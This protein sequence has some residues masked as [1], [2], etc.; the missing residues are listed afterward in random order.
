MWGRQKL[1][2]CV[3][4]THFFSFINVYLNTFMFVTIVEAQIYLKILLWIWKNNYLC[5]WIL[6]HRK[7]I[8][9]QSCAL[10]QH[11]V[12]H[13]RKITAPVIIWHWINT[14]ATVRYQWAARWNFF[15][16]SLTVLLCTDGYRWLHVDSISL[17]QQPWESVISP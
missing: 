7:D 3:L 11:C 17:T 8:S 5:I 6:S 13:Y 4:V 9:L 15:P 12:L 10:N 1:H 16:P 2:A 14:R